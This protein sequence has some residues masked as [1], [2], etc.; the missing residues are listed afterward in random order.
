VDEQQ[1]I[2]THIKAE[3]APLDTAIEQTITEIKLI[4]EYRDRLIAD[5]VTGQV[6]LRGWRP[7]PDDAVSD[8]VLAALG[9][10][11][12]GSADEEEANGDE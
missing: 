2:V 8:D 6:D 5:A 11:E 7:G 4:R 3:S 12:A 9:D 10:D 1:A